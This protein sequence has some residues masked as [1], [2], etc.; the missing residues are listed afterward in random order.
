MAVAASAVAAGGPTTAAVAGRSRAAAWR[1][2]SCSSS[3]SSSSARGWR[4]SRPSGTPQGRRGPGQARAHRQRRGRRGRRVLRRRRGRGRGGRLLSRGPG[5]VGARDEAT[6]ATLAG[7]TCSWSGAP[8]ADFATRA[9][10]TGP[11]SAPQPTSSTCGLVNRED[12][13][14]DRVVVRL[15]A[16]MGD[17]CRTQRRPRG[18]STTAATRRRAAP[19]VLDAGPRRRSRWML[20]SIEQQAEGD[21]NL[22]GE[23]VASPVERRQRLPDAALARGRGGDRTHAAGT[24]PPTSWTRTSPR[25]P[26]PRR[27]DLSLADARFAPEVHRRP[28]VAPRGRRL[29]GG[30]RRPRRR[31]R[32]RRPADGDARAAAPRR[33]A[34]GPDDPPGRPRRG[35]RSAIDRRA[36]D[37]HPSRR[38]SRWPVD[39]AGPPLHR[40]PRHAPVLSGSRSAQARFD[41]TGC[42]P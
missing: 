24:R 15:E 29:G 32:G 17:W 22:D 21:R 14:E 37:A 19:R 25:T 18:S 27:C 20:L 38:A 2:C 26:A 6:L 5:G 30:R 41:E 10:T 33:R 35:R 11:K 9:G 1:S 23:L 7:P 8:P 34:A 39:R 40:G 4:S 3:C 36:L 16:S 12:D 31:A 13:S 42:S 28:R